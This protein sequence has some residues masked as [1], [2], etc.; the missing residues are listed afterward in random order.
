MGLGHTP[1]TE[2]APKKAS[3]WSAVTQKKRMDALFYGGAC[4]NRTYGTLFTFT[5]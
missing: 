5:V 1:Y 4:R 3:N 2:H